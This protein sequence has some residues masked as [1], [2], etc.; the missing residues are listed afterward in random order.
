ML[1]S[2]KNNVDWS[3]F[4]TPEQ[5]F[6]LFGNS[7]R[8]SFSYDSYGNRTKFSAIVLSNPLPIAPEDI[9]FFTNTA[10]KDPASNKVDKFVYRG[11]IIGQNSPHQFLPDPCNAT[12]ASNP[13]QALNIIAMHTLFV[14]NIDD[15]DAGTLPRINSIVEVELTKNAFGYNL[16]YGKHL[17]VINNPDKEP[18]N[19]VDCDSLQGIIAN[20]DSSISIGSLGEAEVRSYRGSGGAQDVENGKLPSELL[21][22]SKHHKWAKFLV[23]VVDAYDKLHDAFKA[24]FGKDLILTDHYRTYSAQVDLKS[25]KPKAA[26]TPGT[27]NHGWGLA[28]DFNHIDSAYDISGG[29]RDFESDVYKWLYKNA[30]TYNF[31]NP[32]WARPDGKKPEAWHFESTKKSTLYSAPK[33]NATI[34]KGA[35]DGESD[36]TDTTA[37]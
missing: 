19:N 26:A 33:K 11:R 25:R 34:A 5:G 27:S 18:G 32:S 10:T 23:D 16:Q 14:S 30:P 36:P 1:M 3:S 28:F 2:I 15:G 29:K 9:K 24:H 35:I 8:K 20:A 37:T 17:N 12:F 4:S 6:E 7:I 22:K 13:E 21:K 31:H